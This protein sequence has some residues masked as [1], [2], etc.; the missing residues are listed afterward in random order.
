[1]RLISP[2]EDNAL[3]NGGDD[4]MGNII[5]TVLCAG[6]E[7]IVGA[8]WFVYVLLF[9]LMGFSIISFI[10]KKI[11]KSQNAY[12]G[13]RLLVFSLLQLFSCLL[14]NQFEITIPR[15]SNVFSTMLLMYIGQQINQKW[16]WK[17]DNGYIAL[18]CAILVYQGTLL[19]GMV[20]LD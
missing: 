19:M 11:T 18:V 8:M 9:S 10:C 20:Q 13:Y 7:P 4:Y 3:L 12:N 5:L 16:K 1:M 2:M 15:C 17:F 6:R 14:T